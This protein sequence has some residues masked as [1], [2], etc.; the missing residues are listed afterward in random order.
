[1]AGRF[2]AVVTAMV[3]PFAEDGSLDLDGV[4]ALT[5]HLLEHGSDTVFVT[6]STGEAPTLTDA[7][8]RE[9]FRVEIGRAHV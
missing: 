2:G 6:G 8:K 7:E 3:T 9:V 4:Q 5:A 1:M